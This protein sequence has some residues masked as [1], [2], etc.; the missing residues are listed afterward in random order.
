MLSHSGWC[1]IGSFQ[2][3]GAHIWQGEVAMAGDIFR[4][5]ARRHIGQPPAS[6]GLQRRELAGHGLVIAAKI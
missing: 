3:R 5:Q 4:E 2:G 6:S 1:R